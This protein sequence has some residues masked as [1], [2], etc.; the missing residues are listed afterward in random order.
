MELD[1]LSIDNLNGDSD[2]SDGDYGIEI[3]DKYTS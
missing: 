3:L 2:L 1:Q